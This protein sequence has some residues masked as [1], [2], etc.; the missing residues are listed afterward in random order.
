MNGNQQICADLVG[1]L[2]L[3]PGKS[4]DKG[5]EK[6]CQ[7]E[8]CACLLSQYR[9]EPEWNQAIAGFRKP[10]GESGHQQH[11]SGGGS[12]PGAGDERGQVQNSVP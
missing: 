12:Q 9:S 11:E 4:D 6:G 5:H 2:E 10:E 7:Q 3:K 8:A 1:L